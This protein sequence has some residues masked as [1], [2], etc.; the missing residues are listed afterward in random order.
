MLRF[1]RLYLVALVAVPVAGVA[2]A[3]G[4][5]NPESFESVCDWI[6]F[7]GNCL[8]EFHNDM[9]VYGGGTQDNPWGDC[10]T[11]PNPAPDG[12]IPTEA[13]P[14]ASTLAK[15]LGTPNGSFL[16]RTMLDTCILSQG[17]T[18]KVD[19][20]IDP[21]M[22]PPGEL[23]TPVTYTFTLATAD[24]NTCGTA[25]Y[26]SPHGFS[27]AINGTG[28]SPSGAGGAGGSASA[29]SSSGAPINV[30]KIVACTA[31]LPADTE[32]DGGAHIFSGTYSEVIAPGADLFN[33]TCPNGESH[34][35]NLNEVDGPPTQAD[36]GPFSACPGLSPSVP[37]ASFQVFLGG[38]DQVGALSF[39]IR[40]PNHCVPPDAGIVSS[41]PTQ[42]P[43]TVVYFNCTIPAK[44][45]TCFDGVQDGA[46]TDV[47][48][49][50]PFLPSKCLPGA[51]PARCVSMQKCAVN[52]DCAD[53]FACTVDPTMGT[54]TCNP[55]TRGDCTGLFAPDPNATGSGGG[56]PPIATGVGGSG[57][58]GSG[59][60]GAPPGTGGA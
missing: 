7:P 43:D 9:L 34:V 40:Y 15:K 59:T 1:R 13:S 60:A 31:G 4:C 28:G 57:A 49:G 32:A 38:V 55:G 17:G 25:T 18:V 52:C 30:D 11:Y 6:A 5:S 26:T 29:S 3:H 16:S 47:D 51:C 36:G 2:A 21:T 44:P 14:I 50:G 41:E 46:E 53:G 58:G 45:E 24:G 39:A 8:R 37:S 22:W 19:P 56:C 48:C 42:P 23:A 54:K 20:P 12:G 10:R 33:V 27:I 35:F